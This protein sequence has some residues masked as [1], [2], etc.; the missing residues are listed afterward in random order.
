MRKLRRK[1]RNE[2]IKFQSHSL[3][4]NRSMAPKEGKTFNFN[5][6]AYHDHH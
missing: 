3:N 5:F 2:R 4:W 1:L 6:I